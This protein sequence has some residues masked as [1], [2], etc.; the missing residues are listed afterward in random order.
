MELYKYDNLTNLELSSYDWQ[1]RVRAQAVWKG[2]NRETQE[3]WGL[4]MLLIDDSNC[5][6]HAFA[7]AKYC[8]AFQDNLVEGRIYI[9]SNFKV[10]DF[11]GDETYR[12]VRNKKHIYFTKDTKMKL[13]K[14]GGLKIEKYAFDLFHMTEIDKLA[15]DNRFLV[16]MVGVMKN[17]RPL[18]TS[19]KN[20]Q[21]KQRLKF[22]LVDGSYSVPVTLF[23]EFALEFDKS[24]ERTENETV[25]LI[26]SCARVN[27]YEGKPQL[28]NYPATRI[29]INPNHYSA[30]T[31][32]NRPSEISDISSFEEEEEI[33]LMSLKEVSMLKEDHIQK[34]VCCEIVVNKVI[35]KENWFITKCSSCNKDVNG[36]GDKFKCNNCKRFIPHPKRRFHVETLCSDHTGSAVIVFP[37][38]EVNR[39]SQLSV[40]ELYSPEK[41]A[42]GEQTFPPSLLL[43]EQ[44]KYT[45][46]LLLTEENIKQGSNVYEATE[47]GEIIESC[48]NFTPSKHGLIETEETVVV[49]EM[50][51]PDFPTQTPQTGRSVNKKTRARKNQ[52]LIRFDD[53]DI[54]RNEENSDRNNRMHAFVPAN[55]ADKLEP[56]LAI[57]KVKDIED[58]GKTI[59]PNAF[60]FYDHSELMELTKQTTYLADVVG[61]IKFYQPLADLVNKRGNP[62]KQVK[63]TIT[64][65]RSSVNV[66]FWDGFAEKFQEEMNKMSEI[67]VIVIIASSRVGLWNDKVDMSSVGGTMCY[68]NYN[69]YSVLQL[70][71]KL[72][73]PLFSQQ[74]S[75]V[76]KNREL[77]LLKVEAIKRLGKDYIMEIE[78]KADQWFCMNCNRI[79]P[80]PDQRF[81]I[82]AV[83]SDETGTFQLSLAD[84][85]TRAVLEKQ[86]VQLLKEVEKE[87]A[88]PADFKKLKKRNFTVKIIIREVNVLNN[89]PL[90]KVISIYRDFIDPNTKA[91]NSETMETDQTQKVDVIHK[92]AKTIEEEKNVLDEKKKELLRKNNKKNCKNAK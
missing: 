29:Y 32:K 48:A 9:L 50:E 35:Q 3:F 92:G 20:N 51:T 80:Y 1:C 60:D 31:F 46:R 28:S 44:Q 15:N 79:L 65:G 27:R 64:D 73:E 24:L 41:E 4:N 72:T 5:R 52:Q 62:Q 81:N 68:L 74:I 12:P 39:I 63:F 78:L 86:A 30:D 77:E 83:A 67:P 10:K 59:E 25:I 76:D 42:L 33:K 90:Y 69:H 54:T 84:Q 38:S 58:D 21:E 7:N 37:D 18:I 8:P 66:T 85:P 57:G 49:K 16:D 91:E 53:E 89:V 75:V 55:T 56:K 40:E 13:A 88:F 22:D 47:I 70:R 61:I 11:L 17:R 26:I 2:M 43:F 87:E 23:D 45:I 36:E 6:I 71:K 19:N 34:Q 14:E 82:T